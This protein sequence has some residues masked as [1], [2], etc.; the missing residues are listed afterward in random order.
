MDIRLAAQTDLPAVR[1]LLGALYIDNLSD[2]ERAQGFLSVRF[3]LEHLAKMVGEAGI[4]IGAD[5][6]QN[7]LGNTVWRIKRRPVWNMSGGGGPPVGR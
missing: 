6:P 4:V 3:T 1:D 5:G 2:A 7:W